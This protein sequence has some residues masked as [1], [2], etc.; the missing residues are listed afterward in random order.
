VFDG[1]VLVPALAALLGAIAG[2]AAAVFGQALAMR[3]QRQLSEEEWRRQRKQWSFEQE[4]ATYLG[5]LAQLRLIARYHSEL[6]EA[7]TSKG[8]INLPVPTFVDSDIDRVNA[9]ADASILKK[10]NAAMFAD[11]ELRTMLRSKRRR[12]GRIDDPL[13]INPYRE[14]RRL[15]GEIKELV[16]DRVRAD[17]PESR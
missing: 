13:R 7:K 8:A 12:H 15:H 6:L 4:V 1:R 14:F 17:K 10:V 5:L 9:F 11:Q 2:G 3:H 16:R